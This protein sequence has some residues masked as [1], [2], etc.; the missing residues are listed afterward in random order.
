MWTSTMDLDQKKVLLTQLLG[1]F[2]PNIYFSSYSPL[3]VQNSPRQ[4]LPESSWVRVRNRLSGIC[5]SDL[6]LLYRG[7]SDQRVAAAARPVQKQFYP[8]HEVVGEVIEIGNDVQHIHV[9]DRVALQWRPNCVTAG[10]QPLCY[11]CSTG[12]YNLCDHGSFLAP[13]PL[14]G[15]WSE[16]ML[17]HEQQ[18]F[19]VPAGLTD[20]Q[21]VML[22]PVAVALHAV[23]RHLPKPGDQVLI[24]GAGTVG[25]LVQQIVRALV[26]QCEISM[27]ARYPFQ[28]EQATRLGAA[29]II[30]PRDAYEGVQKATNA[31]V[32]NGFFGNRTLQGGY[33]VIY[34]TIGQKR[35]M[36]RRNTLHHALRWIRSRGTIVLVGLSL[37]P[38]NIDLTPLWQQEISL[39]GSQHHG[40]EYWPVGSHG[41]TSTFRVACDLIQQRRITPEQ[42][43]THHFAL[44]NYQNALLTA[45]KKAESRAIKVVFDYSLLPASVVPNVRAS[46]P[47][48]RRQSTISFM[49]DFEDTG[50]QAPRTS[51]SLEG[52]ENIPSAR[53]YTKEL[54]KTPRQDQ[55]NEDFDDD[56]TATAIPAINKRFTANLR[57]YV[58]QSQMQGN[59]DQPELKR[60]EP[61]PVPAAS[62]ESAAHDELEEKTQLIPQPPLVPHTE[63]NLNLDSEATTLFSR[64]SISHAATEGEPDDEATPDAL[65][66]AH[67]LPESVS[68]TPEDVELSPAEIKDSEI[69]V[70]SDATE[71][72]VDVADMASEIDAVPNKE[73]LAASD[74]HEDQLTIPVEENYSDTDVY[75]EQ[76]A[77]ETDE[78]PRAVVLATDAPEM[79]PS[80]R[81]ATDLSSAVD[82]AL[83]QSAEEEVVQKQPETESVST[84]NT[85]EAP[86]MTESGSAVAPDESVEITSPPSDTTHT[87]KSSAKEHSAES[88]ATI[89]TPDALQ[90]VEGPQT[91]RVQQRSRTRKKKAG[92]R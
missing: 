40:T 70:I 31:K 88:T 85:K 10:V 27:L 67:E 56:D 12:N 59:L 48:I 47:R 91:K 44:D 73:T 29:H 17:L 75:S 4:S 57:P 46:A 15:G 58:P 72:E 81:D 19:R 18:L 26:P 92:S 83:L 90:Q 84:V 23:L 14:G 34:D 62:Q 50:K 52:Q 24:I 20:E 1:R 55:A 60:D 86:A 49:E 7:G 11:A 30:Y 6:H 37:Q 63:A 76:V 2:Y 68:A 80:A 13:Q 45:S 22:E 53:P 21:A 66:E 43:I 3:Q 32:Y 69:P 89:S 33:D 54:A 35:G 42:L 41:Q 61:V 51:G 5:G 78:E 36:F 79:E 39:L 8:G 9:G 74:T 65:D 64:A 38:M 28:V 87:D 82:P 77:I 16:E 25:L 71:N